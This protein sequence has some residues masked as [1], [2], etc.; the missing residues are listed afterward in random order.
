M[1]LAQNIG[2]LPAAGSQ[3]RLQH[4]PP[5]GAWQRETQVAHAGTDQGKPIATHYR[6]CLATLML[7]VYYRHPSIPSKI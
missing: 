4:P 1:R 7:A 5:G 6:T 2:S 3:S